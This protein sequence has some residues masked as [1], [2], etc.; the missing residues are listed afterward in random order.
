MSNTVLEAS[1]LTSAVPEGHPEPRTETPT[2]RRF[3]GAAAA[4]GAPK[5]SWA[6]RMK[7]ATVR[8]ILNRTGAGAARDP[9]PKTTQGV[10][11][12]NS[13]SL[14]KRR[15]NDWPTHGRLVDIELWSLSSRG[16]PAPRMRQQLE[17]SVDHNRGVHITH[18]SRD[19]PKV[20]CGNWG[21]IYFVDF[22]RQVKGKGG[23]TLLPP[24]SCPMLSAAA[25]KMHAVS[26]EMQIKAH[27]PY[28]RTGPCWISQL[29]RDQASSSSQRDVQGP[30]KFH[31]ASLVGSHKPHCSQ[32]LGNRKH[33][34]ILSPCRPGSQPGMIPST[35]S[36]VHDRVKLIGRRISGIPDRNV[37]ERLG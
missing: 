24:E 11:D 25:C 12:S 2:T 22:P 15:D 5:A 37:E 30:C 1:A 33:H 23:A 34:T 19:A 4:L 14:W 16:P 29:T 13:C 3:L 27:T 9:Y 10:G 31:M 7:E 6:K 35:L 8:C 26:L 21:V 18:S 17:I 32:N 36:S 20:R 28:Y